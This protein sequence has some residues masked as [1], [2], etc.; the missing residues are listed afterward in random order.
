MKYLRVVI[1]QKVRAHGTRTAMS[2]AGQASAQV[3][4]LESHCKKSSTASCSG[5][6]HRG[7]CPLG[8]SHSES[9]QAVSAINTR[10]APMSTISFPLF[11]V[12]ASFN[13]YIVLRVP[14]PEP[15]AMESILLLT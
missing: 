5:S 11:I 9:T 7:L 13:V 1:S 8:V 10:H 15:W 4:V 14:A 6:W 2:S 3:K 12:R